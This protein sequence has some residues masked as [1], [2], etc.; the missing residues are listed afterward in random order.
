M[1]RLDYIQTSYL[2]FLNF[3][4]ARISNEVYSDKSY[5]AFKT[6]YESVSQPDLFVSFYVCV[7]CPRS[8]HKVKLKVKLKASV[9]LATWDLTVGPGE[10]SSSF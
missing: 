5:G 8:T 3:T 9:S 10:S 1:F 6:F 4:A 2:T 7:L